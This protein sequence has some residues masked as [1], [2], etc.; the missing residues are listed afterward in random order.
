MESKT[1]R[2]L[3]L[4]AYKI[5][6]RALETIQCAN[7]GH[8]GGS[9]SLA[10]ILSVLYYDKMII[11][12]SDPRMGSRDRL[13]LSKGHCSPALY[14]V[15]AMRGFFPEDDL[16]CFR[17]IDGFLSGHVEMKNVPGVDM[18]TG[19]LGQGLSVGA[20]MALFA[21]TYHSAYTTYVILGDGELNEGQIWE[22]AM[23][24][25]K[26]GLDNLIAIVD[27]NK[28]Q[29]DGSTESI[30]PIEP[31]PDKFVSFGW[32]VLRVDGHDVEKLANAIDAAK[33]CKG[34]PTVII[35]DTIKGKGVSVFE[36]EVRFHGGRPTNEEY[37][38]AYK[39]LDRKITELEA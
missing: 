32:N 29:L 17:K 8:I 38:V 34:M 3:E 18:S 6:K 10:E 27:C 23:S 15:L 5:R 28:L 16:R 4:N 36:N 2:M 9:F 37:D 14:S 13:V 19:S 25:A 26:Y 30:M 11:D 35:A 31:L 12:P 39:E 21:K 33:E 7:S 20:G 22:A 1:K 24:A